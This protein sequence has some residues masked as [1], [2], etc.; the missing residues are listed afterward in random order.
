MGR[1]T[2]SG[3]FGTLRIER[4]W[5]DVTMMGGNW[6]YDPDWEFVD[7]AGHTH[8]RFDARFPTLVWVVDDVHYHDG[9][10]CA[11]GHLACSL[12]FEPIE[13]GRVPASSF[14]PGLVSY[15]LDGEPIPPE[16]AEELL[17]MVPPI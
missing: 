4:E 5:I 14:I 10:E 8:W 11:D 17:G 9:D 1:T 15:Y 3:D 2:V 13:P 6:K 7:R 12:C 16:Q